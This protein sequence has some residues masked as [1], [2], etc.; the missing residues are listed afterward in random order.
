PAYAKHAHPASGFAVAGV[1]AAVGVDDS[2][3]I[4]EARV[5][6]T[7]ACATAQHLKATEAALMGKKLNADTIKAAAAANNNLTCLSDNYASA[8]YRAHLAGVLAG[9]ALADSAAN[10][11]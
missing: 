10:M 4:I 9:R 1:A 6:V 5:A 7:G 3:T 2:G 8:D 11:A